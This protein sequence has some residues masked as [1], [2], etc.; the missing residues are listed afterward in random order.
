MIK[1]KEA[2]IVEGNY[3]KIK[4]SGIFD[5][6]IIVLDGY[7][8][9]KDKARQNMIK[10]LADKCGVIIFTDSDMAGFR[11]R[12][13]LKNILAGKNVRH[14][15]IPDIPGKEKRKQKPSKEGML[16]VEGMS[17]DIIIEAINDALR[18]GG[19]QAAGNAASE[20]K[21]E[22][23]VTKTDLF[24]D[25]LSGGANSSEY[26]LKLTKL[27]GLPARISPNM[28]LDVINRLYTYEEYKKI[29]AAV[30]NE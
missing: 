20:N 24:T 11:I 5:A 14:A 26:R 25:G 18:S 13:F 30:K 28:L 19:S 29:V 12:T 10:M 15:Y 7:M 6:T 22:R 4:L 16:G 8:I 17:D 9:Y 1:I 27:L 23:L 21:T 3:D 2:I